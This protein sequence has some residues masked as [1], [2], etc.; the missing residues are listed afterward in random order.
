M[1]VFPAGCDVVYPAACA[2]GP[3]GAIVVQYV[4]LACA[5]HSSAGAERACC[6]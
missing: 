3:G 5:I 2:R 1:L 4:A 6:R